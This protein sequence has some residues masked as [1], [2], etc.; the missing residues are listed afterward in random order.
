MSGKPKSFYLSSLPFFILAHATHH[1]LTALPQPMLPFMQDEFNLNKAQLGGVT[2]AFSIAG[3]ASQLPAGWLADRIGP[4]WLIT[5]GVLGVGIAGLFVGLSHSYIMLLACLALMGLMSGGYHPAAAPLISVS[6][7]PNQRGRALGLH[8]IGG[9]ASFFLAPLFAG[10]FA[11][12]WGWRGCF[13]ALSIPTIILGVWFFIY[14]R[15]HYGKSH[16]ESIKL[17]HTGEHPPQP[18]YRR[19]LTAFLTMMVLGGGASASV[20]AFLP[21]YLKES[22]GASNELS[23]M[24]LSIIFSSGLWAAPVGGWLSD[25]FGSVKVVITTGV[26]SGVLIFALKSVSLGWGLW[27]TLWAIGVVQAIRFPVTE[28]FIMSQAPAKNRS[29]IYGVYFSTMQYTGAIFSPL[30]GGFIDRHGY[31]TMFHWTAI[32]VTVLAV[33]TAV[34]IWD[35]K[36]PESEG[37]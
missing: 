16:I 36:D 28:V 3:G 18:G 35:A 13:L 7:P 14:L 33:I 11:V 1:L 31:I 24:S 12:I 21:V 22:L 27:I 15:K 19:R 5:M 17:K 26:L 8:L 37:F 20:N 9:N 23:A 10:A 34:F 6:V 30:L 32:L 4:T 25:R 29:T 2:A